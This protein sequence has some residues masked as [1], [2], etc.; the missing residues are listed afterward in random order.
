MLVGVGGHRRAGV[1]YK[2]LAGDEG[3][4]G[5]VRHWHV[6][7]G[8]GLEELGRE[9][10]RKRDRERDKIRRT[11]TPTT[12][13]AGQVQYVD[14][15]FRNAEAT[16]QGAVPQ[17]TRRGTHTN[18]QP[19]KLANQTRKR[20]SAYERQAAGAFYCINTITLH[21]SVS[22]LRPNIKQF[23]QICQKYNRLPVTILSQ[24]NPNQRRRQ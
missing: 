4:E 3:R 24:K 15:L 19:H 1:Q 11:S 9:T 20:V 14:A 21:S 6:L 10:Q 12:K 16:P 5:L 13:G 17:G 7:H 18:A 8:A 2:M 22:T 23:I